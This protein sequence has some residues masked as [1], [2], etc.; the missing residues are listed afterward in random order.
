MLK[1]AI[2][3]LPS[4]WAKIDVDFIGEKLLLNE[5]AYYKYCSTD[6][7]VTL[8]VITLNLKLYPEKIWS[9]Y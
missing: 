5:P 1:I 8:V 6:T 4:G 9:K 3:T 2:K 7:P